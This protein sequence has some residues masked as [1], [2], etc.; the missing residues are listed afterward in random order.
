MHY[1]VSDIKMMADNIAASCLFKSDNATNKPLSP[2]QVMTLL[3][4]SNA[5]G[6]HPALG[7]K[8]YDIIVGK[9]VKK[10]DAMLR[11]LLL[12]GGSVVWHKLD[13]TGATAT[14]SHPQG[15]TVKID[16]DVKRATSAG[17]I[18]K[19]NWKKHRRAMFRA[20]CVGEGIRAI[21][22]AAASGLYNTEE[23]ADM[24]DK[25][26]EIVDNPS[27]TI[28]SLAEK[29]AADIEAAPDLAKLTEV[30]IAHADTLARMEIEQPEWAPLM[31]DKFEKRAQGLGAV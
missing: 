16:W 6:K 13:D 11:D 21:F 14:F 17:L 9:P 30:Y 31:Q 25:N 28:E 22:P 29:L 27:E 7:V 24:T 3:L 10:T 19:D 18:N 4:I 26:I 15:G 23:M 2:S 20:R 5:E 8:D 1:S 12:N